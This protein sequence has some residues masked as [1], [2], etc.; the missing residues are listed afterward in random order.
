MEENVTSFVC[1][2]VSWLM[3]GRNIEVE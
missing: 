3:S 2:F 1:L